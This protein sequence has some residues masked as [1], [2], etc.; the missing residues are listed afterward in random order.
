MAYTTLAAVKSYLSIPTTT[1]DT[2]LT[3]LIPRAQA[4]I[5]GYC[6]RTFEALVDS[7]KRFDAVRDAGWCPDWCKAADP[8]RG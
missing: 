5:D 4:M 8:S 1:D 3:D 7:T 6:K 2:V